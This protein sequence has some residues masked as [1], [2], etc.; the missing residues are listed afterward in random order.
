VLGKQD[1]TLDDGTPITVKTGA[2]VR[3]IDPMK[4]LFEIEEYEQNAGE[5]IQAAIGVLLVTVDRTVFDSG[6][7]RNGLLK[8]IAS[9]ADSRT[10]IYGVQ[11]SEV[12]F[13]SFSLALPTG[14]LMMD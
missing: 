7:K 4:A 3:V 11:V 10:R 8:R 14:R 12:W 6:R 9:E 1:F 2:M 5:L 13:T